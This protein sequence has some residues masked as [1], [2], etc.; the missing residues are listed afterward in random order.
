MMICEDGRLAVASFPSPSWGLLLV[1][2]Q[3]F[4]PSLCNVL[5]SAL[6]TLYAWLIT[7][8]R[9]FPTSWLEQRTEHPDVA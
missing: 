4:L 7:L 8:L 6:L 3:F 5:F 9:V 1:L 2:V